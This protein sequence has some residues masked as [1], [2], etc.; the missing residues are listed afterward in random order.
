VD[1][2]GVSQAASAPRGG[3]ESGIPLISTGKWYLGMWEVDSDRRAC[4]GRES[5][6]A[7]GPDTPERTGGTAKGLFGELPSNNCRSCT[8]RTRRDDY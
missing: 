1:D 8:C 3:A 6:P 4:S 7:A 2:H 5:C